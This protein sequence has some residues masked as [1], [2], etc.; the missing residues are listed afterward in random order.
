MHETT[1]SRH[2]TVPFSPEGE[3]LLQASLGPEQNGQDMVTEE[4]WRGSVCTIDP[5]DRSAG[6]VGIVASIRTAIPEEKRREASL[7]Y[8]LDVRRAPRNAEGR[9]YIGDWQV[10]PNTAYILIDPVLLDSGKGIGYKTLRPDETYLYGRAPG[11]LGKV[12]PRFPAAGL[13]TSRRH[14]S[15][16]ATKDGALVLKDANSGNG[17][18]VTRFGTRSQPEKGWVTEADPGRNPR[19][20]RLANGVG[21]LATKQYH[22]GYRHETL[23]QE[24]RVLRPE[25]ITAVTEAAKGPYQPGI[26]RE[27]LAKYSELTP[28]AG[29]ELGDKKFLFSG[30]VEGDRTHAV[31]YVQTSDGRVVPRFFYKSISDGGWRV[32]VFTYPNGSYSK[33]VTDNDEIE[34]GGYVQLTKPVEHIAQALE[35]LEAR[36]DMRVTQTPERQKAVDRLFDLQRQEAEGIND[37]RQMVRGTRLNP[38]EQTGFYNSYRPGRGFL[39]AH[40][41]LVRQRLEGLQGP[42]GFEPQF[43]VV[44]RQ[45]AIEHTLAGSTTVQVFPAM[46]CGR[47]IEW[48]VA[49]SRRGDEW[50]D[51]IVFNDTNVSSY[52]TPNEVILAGAL[53]AKP[54]E[55]RAVEQL[56]GMT[57]GID[58]EAY[59]EQHVSLRPI[60]QRMPWLR[61]YHEQR[62]QAR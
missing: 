41:E 24:S 13:A 22:E 5:A 12:D 25:E 34:A 36:E 38:Y 16:G 45:Y 23:Q 58:Y 48:H 26:T 1:V 53:S 28:R 42:T 61:H 39:D 51:R 31:A 15:V 49:T 18:I 55:H 56:T 60:W 8:I 62:S 19:S 33:G 50:V 47:P 52:G 9:K 7:L 11:E 17:S 44:S 3:A 30:V 14:V 37:F 32:A 6:E 2:D 35:T 4:L 10:D 29:I 43:D 46:Y 54:Y 21:S 40:P 27:L 57:L 59:D 20:Q